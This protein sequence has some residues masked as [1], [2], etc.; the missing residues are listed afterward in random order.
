M[1]GTCLTYL[2]PSRRSLVASKSVSS[3]I[4]N[5]DAATISATT[6]SINPGHDDVLVAH[7]VKKESGKS[8]KQQGYF[9]AMMC[10]VLMTS[11]MLTYFVFKGMYDWTGKC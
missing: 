5:D 7:S 8:L 3:T 6:T 11:N 2:K 4:S 10:V 1:S 9:Q